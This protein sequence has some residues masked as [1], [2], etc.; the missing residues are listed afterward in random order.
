M[1]ASVCAANAA[2]D[3][4]IDSANTGMRNRSIGN[5]GTTRRNWPRT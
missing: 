4:H 5:I 3:V 1:Y 2:I